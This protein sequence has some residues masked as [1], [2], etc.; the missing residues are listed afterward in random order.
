MDWAEDNLVLLVSLHSMLSSGTSTIRTRAS[1]HRTTGTTTMGATPAAHRVAQAHSSQCVQR[2]LQAPAV[3]LHQ[4]LPW[5]LLSPC[6]ALWCWGWGHPGAASLWPT[7]SPL[8]GFFQHTGQAFFSGF[9]QATMTFYFLFVSFTSHLLLFLFLIS[10][11]TKESPCPWSH[12][13]ATVTEGS[14]FLSLLK[15]LFQSSASQTLL[16]LVVHSS[17]SCFTVYFSGLKKMKNFKKKV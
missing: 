6:R 15:T 1:G 11:L 12:S 14:L 2:L 5:P 9:Q 8:R 7:A 16:Q 13:K 17:R 3:F 10:I 4:R